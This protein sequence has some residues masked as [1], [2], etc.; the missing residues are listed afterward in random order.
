[1]LDIISNY[2]VGT[3]TLVVAILFT[4]STWHAHFTWA[5]PYPP[6]VFGKLPSPEFYCACISP[7]WIHIIHKISWVAGANNIGIML[8]GDSM[9]FGSRAV[10]VD[11]SKLLSSVY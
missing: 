5:R 3:Y 11:D 10:K 1:M 8:F 9:V 2:V 7:V 6:Q 4:K